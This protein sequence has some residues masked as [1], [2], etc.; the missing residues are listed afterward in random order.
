MERKIEDTESKRREKWRR[1]KRDEMKNL[2]RDRVE[3]KEKKKLKQEFTR[4]RGNKKEG[5][6]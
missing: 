5:G 6:N 4:L 2:Y 1:N 3:R